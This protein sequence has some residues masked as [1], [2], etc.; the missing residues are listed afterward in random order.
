[1]F[2][3]AIKNQKQK[4]LRNQLIYG[5]MSTVMEKQTKEIIDYDW[6]DEL[7]VVDRRSYFKEDYSCKGRKIELF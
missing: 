7:R 1:M 5:I 3:D 2:F 4:M 6:T